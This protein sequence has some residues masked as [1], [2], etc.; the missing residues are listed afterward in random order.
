MTKQQAIDVLREHNYKL[1]PQRDIIMDTLLSIDGYATVKYIYER[2]KG[3]LPCISPDTVYRNL[4]ILSSIGIVDKSNV[5][6][7]MV[8]EMHRDAHT[9]I[10]KC[11]MCG[12]VEKLDICPLDYCL[13]RIKDF[14]VVEHHIEILGYCNKC[15]DRK[16]PDR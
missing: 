14:Q 7:N 2:V 10:M 16:E 8:Y 4:E 9:H 5:G 6:S 1:T 12:K 11:L 13:N 3:K 15:A